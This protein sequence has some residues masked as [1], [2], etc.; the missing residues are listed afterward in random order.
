MDIAD[1]TGQERREHIAAAKED[2]RPVDVSGIISGTWAHMYQDGAEILGFS[3]D[4]HCMTGD[5]NGKN[6]PPEK[7]LRFPN[8]VVNE[9][10]WD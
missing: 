10:A 3:D 5:A 8:A 4:A 7:W 9:S 6:L 1:R 2:P